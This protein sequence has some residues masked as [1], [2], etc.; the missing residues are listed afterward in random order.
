LIETNTF[1]VAF[2]IKRLEAMRN[3]AT[4]KIALSALLQWNFLIVLLAIVLKFHTFVS[5]LYASPYATDCWG[6]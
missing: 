2:S 5:R 1:A 3:Y 4:K 6:T